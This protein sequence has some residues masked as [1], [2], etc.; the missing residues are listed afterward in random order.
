MANK[1]LAYFM[2]ESAKNQEIIEIPGLDSIKD[3]SGKP[4]PLKVKLLSKKEIDD[5]YDKYRT[6]ELLYDKKGKPVINGG[7]AV[8]KEETDTNRALRRIIVEALVYPDLHDKDLMEYYE[9]HDFS[10]MP[11]KVFP[12]FKEYSYIE[13]AVLTAIGIFEDEDGDADDEVQEAK[14]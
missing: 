11:A 9:C 3:E 6:K 8:F 5:I 14:N 12:S 2:R 13:K 10:E 4:I 7:R 1:S